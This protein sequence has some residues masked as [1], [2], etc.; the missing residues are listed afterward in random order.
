M[1]P[2]DIHTHL[3]YYISG[4]VVSAV[5][6]EA[7][8][9]KLEGGQRSVHTL[10]QV[11]FIENTQDKAT[12]KAAGMPMVIMEER[13]ATK[14]GLEYPS[15]AV[16][17]YI[18]AIEQA[19]VHFLTSANFVI[20]GADLMLRTHEAI[21]N[22]PSIQQLM[23]RTMTGLLKDRATAALPEADMAGGLD[24]D[25]MHLHKF[26][27]VKILK[28]RGNDYMKV[29]S[30][31]LR[32]AV[33]GDRANSLRGSLAAISAAAASK[34]KKSAAKAKAGGA[35]QGAG[36]GGGPGGQSGADGGEAGDIQDVFESFEEEMDAAEA[37]RDKVQELAPEP[38]EV[39]TGNASG[40]LGAAAN[41]A[42]ADAGAADADADAH[43]PYYDLAPVFSADPRVQVGLQ[44]KDVDED[45][46][47]EFYVV[48]QRG[49]ADGG[50]GWEDDAEGEDVFVVPVQFAA[51]SV[52]QL[53]AMRKKDPRVNIYADE[54]VWEE[55]AKGFV[56]CPR[57]DA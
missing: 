41:G 30:S 49:I 4:W 20:F 19:Y 40:G 56:L 8:G 51:K 47:E 27:M 5:K 57:P 7:R 24:E 26:M 33:A 43:Q 23:L 37:V 31:H 34:M 17:T 44:F 54:I 25:M 36:Q 38:E 3:L 18:S 11:W 39:D 55:S 46:D 48:K 21:S 12:A 28:M 52:P 35:M 50:G 10:Y 1:E 2:D 14:R 32:A 15:L 42:A 22:D 9:G 53:V 13:E 45:G 16:L 29:I 6:R